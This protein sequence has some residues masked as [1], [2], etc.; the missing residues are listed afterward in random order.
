ML[1]VIATAVLHFIACEYL[2]PYKRKL[3]KW[4]GQQNVLYTCKVVPMQNMVYM[5]W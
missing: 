5:P 4:D 2:L 1:L 3:I